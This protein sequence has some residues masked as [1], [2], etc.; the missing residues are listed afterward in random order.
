MTWS[1]EPRPLTGSNEDY[2]DL[3]DLVGDSPVVLLGEASHGTHEFYRERGRITRRLIEEK[4]FCAVAVQAD[5]PDAYRV[6]RYLHGAPED[7]TA[8]EALGGFR[9]FPAWMWRNAEILS[10]I[11]GL[12]AYNDQ[13][14]DGDRVAF[15]GLDL[16]SLY[17]SIA[18]V[19]DYLE[20][21]DPE[22]AEEA[23]ERYASFGHFDGVH[24]YAHPPLD[25]LDGDAHHQL[26]MQLVQLHMRGESYLRRDGTAA[27]HDQFYAEQN[28]RLVANAEHYYRA[29]LDEEGG[30]QSVRDRHMAETL[31][32]LF[33]HLGGRMELPKVV[34]WAHNLHVGDTRMT[35][36]SERGHVSLGQLVRERWGSEAVL[37]GFTTYSG[38]VTAS[39]AW[40]A[41]PKRQV[42]EA[43]LPDS[44]EAH[45][46]EYGLRSFFL[47]VRNESGS[48]LDT[49]HLERA[50]G[51]IYRPQSER[52]SHYFQASL[53]GQFDAVIHIDETRA[54]E[55][56][57]R[58][59]PWERDD[60]P[61]QTFP[62]GF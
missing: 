15:F 30:A 32:Q 36:L 5:W 57:E 43:A 29:L 50:I 56:L 6:N 39:S 47:D 28:A 53:H 51:V 45:F 13:R 19:I 26:I 8:E 41:P 34:V 62:T 25:R 23:R 21:V 44:Y 18:S 2:D 22:A 46:H 31:S 59:S 37:V 7:E 3:V 40:D 24:V 10:A 61:P 35:E 20:L 49:P 33:E 14:R 27:E 38:T 42:L 1:P 55:P 12:R 48:E 52:D 9:R 58:D 16:Y 54:V 11:G 4:G 17:S 60:D